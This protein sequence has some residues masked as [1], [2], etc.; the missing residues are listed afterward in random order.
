M[1][2]AR[3]AAPGPAAARGALP[4]LAVLCVAAYLADMALYL[5]MTAAPYRA[6]ALGA[7]PVILGVLPAARALPYS[8]STVWA[9]G[10]TEGRERLKA[11]RVSL[12]LGALAVAA[13]IV[14]PGIPWLLVLLAVLG[15]AL[16]F[17]WPAVQATLAD[18]AGRGEVTANLGWFNIAWSL[19]KGSGFLFGGLLLAG[20]GFGA[21]FAASAGAIL[22]V[23]LLVTA[24]RVRPG[25]FGDPG[26][27]GAASGPNRGAAPDR[28]HEGAAEV[29]VGGP[30]P[31]APDPAVSRRFRHAAWVANGVGFG[32]VAVLNT[33]YP[34]WLEEIGRG[35]T[36]FGTY[37]GLIF[38]SQTAAFI[39][40]TRFGGWRY[41]PGPLLLAQLPLLP[42]LAVLPLLR[43]P[44]AILAT[45]PLVGLGL[46][47]T[48]F[49]S[50]FYSVDDP[51]ARG[52]NAG[53]HEMLL[54]VGSLA[55]PILGGG[56]AQITGHLQA[57]YLFTAAAVAVS[58]GWQALHLG[59]GARN[60]PASL[61][62]C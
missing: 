6:L 32:V 40:L 8:L 42:I 51:A 4:P 36:V 38:F 56:L 41:R 50:L 29:A 31:G 54:G 58:I 25:A 11:A 55:L 30:A 23:A 7:G 27:G 5:V 24:I 61:G 21:V 52:R 49:A 35:E 14:A 53:I 34:N 2:P 62:V 22:A 33:H 10:F 1:T 43:A 15:T 48:Y 12:A 13:L 18:L 57:P 26:S 16:A 37:L 28:G 9:G 59:W 17:F 47:M 19:G 44:A 60:R 39:V 46:G 3:R 45:A 20:L